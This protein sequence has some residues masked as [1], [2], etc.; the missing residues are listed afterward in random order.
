MALE[1]ELS[2]VRVMAE[3]IIVVKKGAITWPYDIDSAPEGH[4]HAYAV[5]STVYVDLDKFYKDYR[6]ATWGLAA[7]AKTP[8]PTEYFWEWIKD[9][10][11]H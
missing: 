9:N 3:S 7:D 8:T 1:Y 5:E 2:E 4:R 11:E 6:K 10:A